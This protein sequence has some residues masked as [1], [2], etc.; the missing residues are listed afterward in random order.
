[1]DKTS[2]VMGIK[3]NPRGILFDVDGT[4]YHHNCLR[5]GV[6]ILLTLKIVIRPFK[7]LKEIKIIRNYRFAQEW[8]RQNISTKALSPGAQLDRTVQTSGI[9]R[10]E[11]SAC[12]SEWMERI[13]LRFLPLCSRRRLIRLIHD[14]DKLGVPMGVYSDYPSRDKLC[15]L[16]LQNIMRVAVSSEDLDVLSFKPAPRGFEV[17]VAKMG[18]APS[19]VAYIGDREDVDGIGAQNA[20]MTAIIVGRKKRNRSLKPKLTLAILDRKL[21]EI[22]TL[23]SCPPQEG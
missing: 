12:I 1:M 15:K 2:E 11:V 5:F 22:C 17:A 19:Q 8:L 10:E 4:L 18:L 14:W 16:G 3:K 23:K 21:R 7:M 6:G 9:P 13:P 20:G